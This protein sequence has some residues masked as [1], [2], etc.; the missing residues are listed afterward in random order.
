M[1][2]SIA[3]HT[4]TLTNQ[5]GTKQEWNLLYGSFVY[6]KSFNYIEVKDISDTSVQLRAEQI[7]EFNG[8]AGQPDYSDI[9]TA[10][11]TATKP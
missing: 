1:K 6:D 11:E 3:N 5:T 7:T 8:V 2:V 4:L 10:L 9:V